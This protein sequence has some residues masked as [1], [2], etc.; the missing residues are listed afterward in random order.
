MKAK[1]RPMTPEQRKK[2]KSALGR[3]YETIR[4]YAETLI[5]LVRF[6]DADGREIGFDYAYIRGAILKKFPTVKRNGRHKGRKTR[7]PYKELQEF[8]CELNRRGI[9]LPFRPRRKA[10]MEKSN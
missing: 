5:Q 7:M 3:K 4:A 8:A 1:L 6:T 2:W 9:R 10:K